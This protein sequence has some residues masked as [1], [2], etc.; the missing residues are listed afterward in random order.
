M[1]ERQTDRETK[2]TEERDSG[3]DMTEEKGIARVCERE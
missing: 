1:T 2:K 3:V